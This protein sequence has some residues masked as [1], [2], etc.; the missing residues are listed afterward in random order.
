MRRQIE[1]ASDY[2]S[3]AIA[4]RSWTEPQ[5]RVS[6][7]AAHLRARARRYRML[8]ELLFDAR[9]IAAAEAC[10]RELEQ[11]ADEMSRLGRPQ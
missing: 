3:A 11:A 7:A 8:A 5:A 10:A 2:A 6:D 9:V 1:L 4:S